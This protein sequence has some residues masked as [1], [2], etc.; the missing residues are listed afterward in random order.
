MAMRSLRQ[1]RLH[2][3][4]LSQTPGLS[5]DGAKKREGALP[6]GL[7]AGGEQHVLF[8]LRAVFVPAEQRSGLHSYLQLRDG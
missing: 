8:R 2:G 5:A 4:Q 7:C 3:S 1:R 6:H